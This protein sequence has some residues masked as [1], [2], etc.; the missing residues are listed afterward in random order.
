[1]TKAAQTAAQR[2][3]LKVLLA[4]AHFLARGYASPCADGAALEPHLLAIGAEL[5]RLA[6]KMDEL[7]TRGTPTVLGDFFGALG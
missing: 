1:M 7:A 6:D 2:A 4:Q 3:A 5:R